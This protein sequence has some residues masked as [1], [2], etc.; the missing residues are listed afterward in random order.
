MVRIF[1][2]SFLVSSLSFGCCGGAES[3]ALGWPDSL[4]GKPQRRS[5]SRK[6]L[7]I[8]SSLKLSD[9]LGPRMSLAL[10][11]LTMSVKTNAAEVFDN[12][13][14]SHDL[15]AGVVAAYPL[16]LNSRP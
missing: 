3:A 6:L 16:V 10:V 12:L 11:A 7:S 2:A 9:G 14:R 8:V 4:T 13:N 5:I 1:C 15:V